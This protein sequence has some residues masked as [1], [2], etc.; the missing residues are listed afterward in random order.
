MKNQVKDKGMENYLFLD[1]DGVL[2]SKESFAYYF[3]LRKKAITEKEFYEKIKIMPI[4]E[5]Y[6]KMKIL[7]TDHVFVP[8]LDLLISFINEYNLKV[9]GISSWCIQQPREEISIFMGIDISGKSQNC[10]GSANQRTE[11][12]N[13]C[14][15]KTGKSLDQVNYVIFDDDNEYDNENHILVHKR[16]DEELLERARNILNKK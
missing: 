16:I 11:S 13:L 2:N 15:E 7:S 6:G 14:F 12:V 8:H 3:M 5:K 4:D 9:V 1:I 10:G